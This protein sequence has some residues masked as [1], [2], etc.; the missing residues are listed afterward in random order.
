M[1]LR[2]AGLALNVTLLLFHSFG[3]GPADTPGDHSDLPTETDP[4]LTGDRPV[5]IANA[6]IVDGSG[7]EPFRGSL[8]MEDGRIAAIYYDD[9]KGSANGSKETSETDEQAAGEG[10]SEKN[11]GIENDADAELFRIDASGRVVAPGFIDAHSHGNPLSTPEFDNFLHMGVTTI[12]LGQDGRSPESGSVAGWMDRV[13]SAGTGVNIVH[14]IGHGTVRNSV[15]AP[16]VTGLQSDILEQ[17]QEIIGDAMRDGSFGLS[18]G[19]EYNPGYHSDIEEL[20][21]IARP[22]AQYGGLVMSHIRS[23]D[24]D[25]V[26][27]AI[28]E[29]IEQGRRSGARV[30]VSHIKIVYG[31]GEDRAEEVLAVLHEAREEGVGVTADLYPYTASFTGIG[32]VFPDWAMPPNNY[33]SVRTHRRAELAEFLHDRVMLRNGPEATLFGTEPWAGMTLAE[34]ADSLGKPFTDVLIDD[35][36]PG[37]AGAAYFVMDEDVM[38]RLLLDPLVMVSS[39][40]SPTMRHP[41]GYGSFPKVIRQFVIEEEVLSLEEAVHKMTGLTAS[42][43][44]LDDPGQVAVPR[45][46]IREGFAADLVLFEPSRVQDTATFEEPHNLAAGMSWV[47]VGGVPVIADGVRQPV[48]PAGVIRRRE[49]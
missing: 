38:R 44:G 36:P 40:G 22:V 32:I 7:S 14:F 34:V 46:L 11:E 2:C 35:I 10:T 24:D 1:T 33:D 8:L 12:T 23:E 37:S 5:L 27:E 45:G 13:D 41:R 18:T 17:M 49:K 25:L 42:T 29:L 26:E 16:P 39:D 30:H 15:E 20:A 4:L 19:I 47:F 21:A 48:N 6:L 28:R 43:L 3:C 31:K 9:D